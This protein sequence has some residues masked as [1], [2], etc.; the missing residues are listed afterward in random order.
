LYIDNLKINTKKRIRKG[1]Q[2]CPSIKYYDAKIAKEL[3]ALYNV[4]AEK[5]GM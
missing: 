2:G 5:M 4:F 1:Y 3:H